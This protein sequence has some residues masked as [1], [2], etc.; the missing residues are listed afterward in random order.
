M[1]DK[2]EEYSR[3][4]LLR[5]IRER[6]RKPRFGLVWERKEIEHERSIND[7]FVMLE[8]DASLS[9][10]NPPHQ[11]LVIEGDNFDALRYLRM[12]HAGKVRCIYID[13]P[14]N[15][16]NKDFIYND[17][18][19]DKDDV[20]K[21]SKWLEF[22]YRRLLIA[23]DLLAK[24]GVIFCS[25]DD[26]EMLHLGMLMDQVFGESN[27]VGVIVWN[28][29]SRT[30]ES[31]AIEHEY[32]FCYQAEQGR[33]PSWKLA[34]PEVDSAYQV[35][36]KVKDQG[37][38]QEQAI[39]ALKNYISDL[40]KTTSDKKK[41]SWMNNYCNLDENWQIYY[42]VDL[43]GDG[44]GPP[45]MFGDEL[46]PP[47]KGRH[48]MGQDYID[49]AI[50]EGRIVWRAGRAYRK[51]L[52]DDS[53]ESVRS[54]VQIPGRN[55]TEEIKGI[56]KE[57]AFNNPKP[58]SLV[59]YLTKAHLTKDDLILDFFAGSGTTGHAVMKLNAEDGGNRRFILVSSTE[60]NADEPDKNICRDVCAERLRRV[61]K[62]Y[63]NKKGEVVEGLGGGFAYMRTKRIPVSKVFNEI[64]HDQV[65]RALQLIHDQPLMDFNAGRALQ[66]TGDADKHVAYL[67][68]LDEA[69]LALIES[70]GAAGG[71]VTVYSWQ[72]AQLR[73][74][75]QSSNVSFEKI[76]E[77]L[78]KRFGGAT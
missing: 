24:D 48:W 5:L 30:S 59:E 70:L 26:N 38:N 73:Q 46:I 62:G 12:T 47:P 10:G 6:D 74:R 55:G 40:K 41:Y 65:W 64:Q 44:D 72:P 57:K 25:I 28:N 71:L 14:Y 1:S 45:R 8:H 16:G 35:V 53:K 22:M 21:H 61:V 34:R 32:V 23:K 2:Y 20:Y 68:K 67:A 33:L 63:T 18:F 39:K 77:F 49:E 13:P 76:P 75:I 19:V 27:R 15:T 7:D 3:E 9:V 54:I 4:E 66:V 69:S 50:A 11:N 29:A 17:R 36:N 31:I 37:G 58:T 43:S 42:P 52:I 60:A 56:L 78:V 51:L